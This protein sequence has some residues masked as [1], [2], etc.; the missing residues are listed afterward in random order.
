L[1]EPWHPDRVIE[2]RFAWRVAETVTPAAD[3]ADAG[4]RLGLGA[5][6]V[7][8]LAGRGLTSADELEAFFAEPLAG[9]H[10]P[11]LLPD[12]ELFLGRLRAARAVGETVMVFGDFDADGLT[13][14]AILVRALRRWGMNPLPYVPSRLDEGHGLSAKA[15]EAAR[16][17]GATLIVT[18]DC[19]STSVPE[20]AAAAAAG[21]DVIVTDHHRL[22]AELPAAIAIVNPQRADSRYPERRLAG[23]GVAFKLAQLL[24]ADEPGGPEAALELCDLAAIG[25]IADLV[26][27]LG[28]TRAIVRLGLARIAAA[29]RPGIAALL[30]AASVNPAAADVETLS[31]AVAPR[32]NAAGR[33][34]ESAAAAALLMTDDRDEADRLASELE[35]ANRTR[36]DLTSQAMGEARAVIAGLA[37]TEPPIASPDPTRTPDPTAIHTTI[38]RGPWP[39]GIVGLVASRLVE[40]HGRSAVVGAELGD[41]IRASCRSDG[42]LD[43]GAT[44]DACGPIFL[45]H[46]GHAGAAG[47]EIEA[48]RWPEFVATFDALAA[49]SV[50][51]DPR[52]PLAIDLAL[53]AVDVDYALHRDLRRLD[54]CGQGNPEPL[55]IVEGLTVIRVRAAT[56]GHTQLTLRRR[57]DVLDGIAFGRPDLAETVH[58]GDRVD[59]VARL[60][61]RTFGGY[62]SLQLDI[63]DVASAGLAR[64]GLPAVEAPRSDAGIG[65]GAGLALPVAS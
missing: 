8:L 19:G 49:R 7:G 60:T 25:S 53:P 14:L 37:A 46:G 40:D 56:G 5:R 26:P 22:P 55:L 65:P 36:R 50:P 4:T 59:V 20:I 48:A 23:S 31:F 39:V 45:R 41:I 33:V 3:L 64:A 6:L 13:G 17:A 28:E 12:A 18:V 38:V 30:A 24:L 1:I 10:D 9:L 32:I 44:L 15:I 27:I 54:P 47:F 42:R 61:S 29:P 16:T 43:L 21:I 52:L 11:R 51:D 57:L 58:E 34:G 62:E 63:R 35:T 2:P